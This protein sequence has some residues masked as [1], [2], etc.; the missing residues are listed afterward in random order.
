MAA[1]GFMMAPLFFKEPAGGAV[2]KRNGS[3][4]VFEPVNQSGQWRDFRDDIKREGQREGQI[5]IL[6]QAL[7]A[8]LPNLDDADRERIVDSWFTTG[9][10]DNM[11]HR[12][13]E[14]GQA[15]DNWESILDVTEPTPPSYR[16]PL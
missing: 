16:E 9:I 10:P 4:T 8:C 3:A 2:S 15:S 5:K 1:V 12:I 11:L 13:M 6:A 7:D 14:A